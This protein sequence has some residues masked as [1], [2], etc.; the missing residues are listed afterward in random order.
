MLITFKEFQN[1]QS[2]KT[3]SWTTAYEINFQSVFFN[4][5]EIRLK[6]GWKTK[7][8]IVFLNK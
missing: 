8:K 4:I 3:F 6:S 1:D 2:C 7:H 5:T